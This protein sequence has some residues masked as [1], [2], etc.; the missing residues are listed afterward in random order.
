MKTAIVYYSM[1]GNSAYAAKLVA[2]LLGADLIA[3]EPV[4]AFPD[5]GLKK[6]LV[7]G[8]SALRKEEPQLKPYAFNGEAYDRIIFGSPVWASSVTPPIRSFIREN[9]QAIAGK[10]FAAFAC[11]SGSGGEKML[12][13]LQDML[14]SE[15]EAR[16]VLIDPKSRPS[17]ENEEKIRAFCEGLK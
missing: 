15:L 1:S 12:S 16:M 13:S 17:A 14:G 4:E 9:R 7:G 5:K 3:I 8:R 11:C 6:F 10:R 2:D